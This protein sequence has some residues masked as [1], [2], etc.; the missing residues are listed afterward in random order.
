MHHYEKCLIIRKKS[1]RKCWL[2]N[3]LWDAALIIYE[4]ICRRGD[5]L[6]YCVDQM[7]HRLSFHWITLDTSFHAHLIKYKM[8]MTR[9]TLILLLLSSWG[10][11]NLGFHLAA[12]S[13][14]EDG[15]E[16]RSQKKCGWRGINQRQTSRPFFWIPG[17]LLENRISFLLLKGIAQNGWDRIQIVINTHDKNINPSARQPSASQSQHQVPRVPRGQLFRHTTVR[18]ISG[19]SCA[20]AHRVEAADGYEINPWITS[21]QLSSFP[22]GN[23][24]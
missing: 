2:L 18:E 1:R 9:Q 5:A 19:C 4:T 21:T 16:S 7:A 20:S 14:G 11:K 23:T 12:N 6:T 22:P 15:R 13:G 10:G 8:S 17:K 24:G 3:G